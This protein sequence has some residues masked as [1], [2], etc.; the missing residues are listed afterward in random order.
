MTSDPQSIFD[1]IFSLTVPGV[2]LEL[3]RVEAFMRGIDN[4]HASY[5]V[6]HIAGTNGKGSTA[7]MLAAIMGAQGYKTGLFTSP[8]LV[9]PN[10]RIRIGNVLVPDAF[11]VEM[12]D[13]WRTIID[14]HGITFFEVLTALGM[15]YFK[16][17]T[18]DYAVIETGLGGRLDATNVVDPL[19]SIITSVSMDHENILGDTIQ[20]IAGEKAGIIKPG[21][22]VILGSNTNEVQDVMQR[23]SQAKGTSYYYVPDVV[24]VESVKVQGINQSVQMRLKNK[25]VDVN[26]PLL[27]SHQIDN[28]AN[29]L[30]AMDQLGLKLDS[31]LIQKGLD[32]MV[33]LGRMQALQVDPLVL[34]DVAHNVEGLKQLLKSLQDSGLEDTI[35]VAAFNARKNI[36]PMLEALS[37]WNGSVLFTAFKGHSS[38]ERDV[39]VGLGVE[40]GKISNNLQEAY[41]QAQDQKG[42]PD[43]AICFMG[44]HYLAEQLFDLFNVESV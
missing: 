2:K 39:L 5:P 15:A 40:P 6:I 36:R 10:E 26:L 25:R 24:R 42:Y 34:Y 11:I 35:V 27:G 7:A 41:V 1:Y 31:H 16:Q 12:V 8:H 44:S 23:E 21:R 19:L 30:V 4:P 38:V 9:Q 13:N 43:Q 20:K 22:P 33:W 37:N 17:E 32:Q 3:S 28:F 14:K 18:V 29:V